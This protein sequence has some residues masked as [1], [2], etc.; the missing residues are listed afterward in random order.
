MSKQLTVTIKFTLPDSI[1]DQRDLLDDLTKAVTDR[2]KL[3]L[4]D[5]YARVDSAQIATVE[6]PDME[7]S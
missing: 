4:Q 3:R 1:A 5:Y 2:L 6:I 7:Q